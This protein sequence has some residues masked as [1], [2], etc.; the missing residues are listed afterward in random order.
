MCYN[1]SLNTVSL[2][3]EKRFNVLLKGQQFNPVYHVSGFNHKKMPVITSLQPNNFQLFEWGLI[4]QWLK[5]DT[6]AAQFRNYTL[7]ARSESIFEKSAFKKIISSQR[8]LIPATGFFEFKHSGNN[9]IP[10]FIFIPEIKIFSFAGIWDTYINENNQRINT[11]SIITKKAD[12]FMSEIHNS[13]KRMPIILPPEKEKD[14]IDIN[15]S[16]SNIEQFFNLKNPN[17]DAYTVS[18]KINNTKYNSDILE[19]LNKVIYPG[20]QQK[21]DF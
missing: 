21:F 7:N 10:Y 11:Y 1:Y 16:K 8:C 5:N 9:I 4:P 6:K 12:M 17:L 18:K 15:L 3:L 20:T 13:K 14:W 2:S 19:I